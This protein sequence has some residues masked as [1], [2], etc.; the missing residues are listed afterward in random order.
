MLANATQLLN[1]SA[2]DFLVINTMQTEETITIDPAHPSLEGHF[3]GNP[4]VP[5]VVILGEVIEALRKTIND[6]MQVATIHYAKFVSSLKPREML[7]IRLEIENKEEAT[8]T[9][10]VGSRLISS[11]SLRFTSLAG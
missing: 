4:I 6:P 5:A 11:G 2:R 8:F 9:C 10:Q 7:T 1:L 3:P